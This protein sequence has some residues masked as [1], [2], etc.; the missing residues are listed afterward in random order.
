MSGASLRSGKSI[1]GSSFYS[2]TDAFENYLKACRILLDDLDAIESKSF[3]DN[4]PDKHT[5]IKAFIEDQSDHAEK[6]SYF[7]RVYL[8]PLPKAALVDQLTALNHIILVV[9]NLLQIAKGL[10]ETLATNCRANKETAL[11]ATLGSATLAR[12][13]AAYMAYKQQGNSMEDA[14]AFLTSRSWYPGF[15]ETL[16]AELA[17]SFI[18]GFKSHWRLPSTNLATMV[19]VLER[20]PV[21]WHAPPCKDRLSMKVIINKLKDL[22]VNDIAL[23]NLQT[24][25]GLGPAFEVHWHDT[26]PDYIKAQLSGEEVEWQ[27]LQFEFIKGELQYHH[28]LVT[29]HKVFSQ[30]LS[31]NDV[32]ADSIERDQFCRAVFSHVEALMKLSNKFLERLLTYQRVMHP[33]LDSILPV[34]LNFVS[35][36]DLHSELIPYMAN[37]PLAKHLVERE[38]ALNPHFGAFIQHTR[39]LPLLRRH[40]LDHFIVRPVPRVLRTELL[41]TECLKHTPKAHPDHEMGATINCMVK[42]IADTASVQV[43][44]VTSHV[45][46]LQALTD[47]I[48]DLDSEIHIAL[49]LDPQ[50]KL[51]ASSPATSSVLPGE[52]AIQLIV[53]STSVF[54]TAPLTLNPGPPLL[55]QKPISVAGIT[56]LRTKSS[57]LG[58]QRISFKA[59]NQ[60]GTKN[61]ALQFTF[62]SKEAQNDSFKALCAAVAS[63]ESTGGH[64][65]ASVRSYPNLHSLLGSLT[66]SVPLLFKGTPVLT[67]ASEKGLY[68]TYNTLLECSQAE[69][70]SVGHNSSEF[71]IW[72]ISL[73]TPPFNKTTE[74]IGKHL[75]ISPRAFINPGPM[76]KLAI[77]PLAHPINAFFMADKS[78]EILLCLPEYGVFLSAF[79]GEVSRGHRSWLMWEG[80]A[81]MVMKNGH[82]LLVTC[83]TSLQIFDMRISFSQQVIMCPEAENHGRVL[84]S[85]G[86]PPVAQD[87]VV[88]PPSGVLHLAAGKKGDVLKIIEMTRAL[89]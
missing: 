22:T 64:L 30:R 26:V 46:Y 14:L 76:A 31:T 34:V 57:I 32:I 69:S 8:L 10:V 18:E 37:Y 50:G 74:L 41:V 45:E 47:V 11:E 82:L 80:R 86:D 16:P 13:Q 88:M 24:S 75:P 58:G 19:L 59:L 48:L 40:S 63:H 61:E 87:G 68:F 65:V 39:P 51:L 44:D 85:T 23:I 60:P 62:S 20:M 67:V 4:T 66:S 1:G 52:T 77:Q 83:H 17:Q 71:S 38:A 33:I 35:S 9:D 12:F 79:T 73:N 70:K 29:L 49:P 6:L 81:T 54:I 28:D 84:W 36:P 89:G 43:R 25:E 15:S 3:N 7:R 78:D 2:M 55:L 27:C 21:E 56:A 42:Q 5:T 53:T 72:Q